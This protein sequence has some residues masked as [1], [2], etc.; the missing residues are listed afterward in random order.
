MIFQEAFGARQ[1]ANLEPIHQRITSGMKA[2]AVPVPGSSIPEEGALSRYVLDP[3]RK[4]FMSGVYEGASAGAGVASGISEA[5]PLDE[6]VSA[7]IDEYSR[8]LR[9][10]VEDEY[11]LDPELNS[12]TANV[13]YGLTNSLTKY[14][15]AAATAAGVVAAAPV[16][17]TAAATVGAVTTAGIFAAQMGVNRAQSLKDQG[18]DA[19]TARQAGSTS[20]AANFVWSVIPGAFGTRMATKAATGVGMSVFSNVSET[21]AIKYILD[22]ADYSKAAEQ[23]D[24]L[25]PVDLG[26]AAVMGLAPAAASRV[27][28][29]RRPSVRE[30]DAA[31]Y[32]SEA[33]SN[34]AELP[35]DHADSAQVFAARRAQA[36]VDRQIQGKEAIGVDPNA[37]SAE[38]IQ[39]IREASAKR[40]A[41][42]TREGGFIRQNRD[43]S[44]KESV[45][46]MN[47]IAAD[48]KYLLVSTSRSLSDGAPV[49]TNATDIPDV[50]LGNAE[51]IVDVTGHVYDARYA[52]IDADQVLTSNAIDGSLNPEYGIDGM[53]YPYAIAGNGRITGLNAAYERGT[54]SQYRADL[55]A[56]AAHGINPDVIN[57]MN[58]PILVRIIREEDMPA[59]IADR[60]NQRSTAEMNFVEQAIQD[61]NRIDL[62][63]LS[64]TEDGNLSGE[65]VSEFV[66]LLPQAERGQLV[67]NGIPTEA[68]Q[69]RLDAAIFQRAYGQPGLTQLLDSS[70][71]PT[72]IAQTLRAMRQLAPRV[73]DLEGAGEFDFRPGLAEVLNEVQMNRANGLNL[74]LREL[75]DQQSMTRSAQ[76]RAF[77]DF[78]ADNAE[79]K[80]GVR[81]IYNT[82]AQ[83]TDFARANK[84]MAD[85]G[86]GLFGA[87]P[88]LTQLDL[89]RE[90]SKI[91]GRAIDE[92]LF[93]DVNARN[94]AQ[95]VDRIPEMK[96]RALAKAQAEQGVGASVGEVNDLVRAEE[97]VEDARTAQIVRASTEAVNANPTGNAPLDRAIAD[98]LRDNPTLT[99]SLEDGA[100]IKAAEYI[101]REDARA[102]EIEKKATEGIETAVI[103][104]MKNNGI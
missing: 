58:R 68:A 35:V 86:E 17:G 42:Q 44:S 84:A 39:E 6:S 21:A 36:A 94:D 90:F 26:V 34:T 63:R 13:I 92:K 11:S 25:N 56:D 3:I 70:R 45:A 46:Q 53:P 101:A 71:A 16:T 24:P 65:A 59:D 54:A 30:E 27:M 93:I 85:A 87:P 60:S 1:T 48:P 5:L 10:T 50:Q 47:G 12:A 102:A 97:A 9:K 61:G 43:R 41:E 7:A 51:K 22:N 32:R 38:R 49:I 37:V 74:T 57:G 14:G 29:G 67:V 66:A 83:L 89:M 77:L 91:T 62:K 55:T 98:E 99:M 80:G 100:T 78:L 82:F 75:A 73:L 23:F 8:S 18:V 15:A 31:R 4:G 95:L 79:Q 81:G 72:G 69:K 33:L 19:R 64:F 103:C 2:T 28:S 104:A 52:V 76:A 40:L 20:A 96:R 88:K